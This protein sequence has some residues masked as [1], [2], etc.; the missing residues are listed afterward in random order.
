VE[1]ETIV[2]ELLDIIV[3]EWIRAIPNTIM[4]A[5][6]LG[7]T[8]EESFGI[9]TSNQFIEDSLDL[10]IKAIM[11]KIDNIENGVAGSEYRCEMCG[12][13]FQKGRSDEEANKEA[14]E[15]FGTP[16]ASEDPNMAIVCD[17]CFNKVRP[18]GDGHA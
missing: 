9:V 10:T 2:I 5:M 4:T 13:S 12:E 3:E 14:E 15:I 8:F 18:Y 1:K 16:N 11:E 17:D 7:K 6:M